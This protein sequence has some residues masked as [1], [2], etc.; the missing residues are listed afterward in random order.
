M[1]K[2][3]VPRRAS[4]SAAPRGSEVWIVIQWKP[5]GHHEFCGVFASERRAVTACRSDTHC[6]C[7]ATVGVELGRATEPW[8]GA[9]YPHCQPRP[10][11]NSLSGPK[12][13]AG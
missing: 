5:E 13:A 7:P 8:P 2:Q 10:P 3:T 11:N 9:W 6:V 1:S 12:P 4:R